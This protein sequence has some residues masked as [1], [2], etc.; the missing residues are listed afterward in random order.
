MR[1]FRHRVMSSLALALAAATAVVAPVGAQGNDLASTSDPL[2]WGVVDR[3]DVGV[4]DDQELIRDI[5]IS[6]DTVYAV[7]FFLNVQP[8]D[9][10]SKVAQSFVAAFD[11][12]TGAWKPEFRP[13]VDGPVLE[14]EVDAQGQVYIGGDFSSVSGAPRPP[15]SPSSTPSRANR[16]TPRSTASGPTRRACC[17]ST[18]S[19]SRATCSTSVAT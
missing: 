14:V 19:P 9:G 3:L 8:T 11:R 10:G 13:V 5:A 6:G 16:P 2:P 17:R 15:A 12:T 4:A 18:H 1:S 7:G